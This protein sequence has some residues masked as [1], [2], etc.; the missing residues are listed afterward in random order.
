LSYDLD[1]CVPEGAPAPTTAELEAYFKGRPWYQVNGTQAFYGNEDTGV[2]FSFELE[3]ESPSEDDEDP[4]EAGAEGAEAEQ[5]ADGLRPIGLSFNV[6]YVR[7][8]VFGLEAERELSALVERFG[9]SVDDP[10]MNG[11]GRGPYSAA[12]FLAGWRA[13]NAF[14]YRAVVEQI[15]KEPGEQGS[16]LTTVLES[17]ELERCWRWNIQRA[18]LQRELGED[19]FV[20]RISFLRRD[21]GIRS[22]VVWGD[23]IPIALPD[24]DVLMLVRQQL[25]P[26]RFLFFRPQDVAIASFADLGPLLALAQE[27]RAPLPHRVFRYDAPPL[28][29]VEF[30]RTRP[31][32]RAAQLGVPLDKI[33]DAELLEKALAA[34]PL[35]LNTVGGDES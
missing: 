30:F 19:V 25:A 14:G 16:V 32:F 10:Q 8:S 3:G 28:A 7:P 23:A 1:F 31:R 29:M 27:E 5:P 4:R 21:G 34:P 18:D 2:Y 9:L 12:G 20:P 24:V 13:G 33:L 17:G 15:R 11:M 35:E 26:R 22:F 6:N